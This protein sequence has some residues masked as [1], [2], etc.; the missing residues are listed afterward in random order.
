M[1]FLMDSKH[2]NKKIRN[3]VLKSGDFKTSNRLLTL[4]NG[5][6][7]QWQMFVDCYK[8]DKSNGR[9]TIT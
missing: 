9:S 8:W 6:S 5:E 4:A 2:V 1:V 7:I 3:N